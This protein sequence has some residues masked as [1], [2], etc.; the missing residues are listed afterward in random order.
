MSKKPN[1]SR[2][3]MYDM[4]MHKAAKQVAGHL[5]E[6]LQK[7]LGKRSITLRKGDTVKVM[8]GSF[9]G[10]EG[11]ITSVERGARKIFIEKLIIKKRNGKD[12]QVKIDASNVLVIDIDRTDRKRLAKKEVAKESEKK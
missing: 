12:I 7:E 4:P 8:R 9:E 11:K 3:E 2:K 5:D 10:K 6:K 1:K